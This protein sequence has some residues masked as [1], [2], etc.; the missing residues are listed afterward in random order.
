VR[1]SFTASDRGDCLIVGQHAQRMGDVTIAGDS[2]ASP[3]PRKY[4]I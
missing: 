1:A 3:I 4:L 2:I